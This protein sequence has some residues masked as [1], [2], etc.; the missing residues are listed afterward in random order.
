MPG[1]KKEPKTE[2]NA[3]KAPRKKKPSV[4]K[5]AEVIGA[6]DI[7]D[8]GAVQSNA[9]TQKVSEEVLSKIQKALALGLHPGGH[10]AEKRHAMRRAT[11]LMQ[12]YGLSQAGALSPTPMLQGVR[13]SCW[14]CCAKYLSM[15]MG[16]AHCS[17]HWMLTIVRFRE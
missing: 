13:F 9:A 16:F 10:E 14:R 5:V 2:A 15:P 7:F 11:R 3:A 17:G 4:K 8:S 6:K 1:P 12:Q